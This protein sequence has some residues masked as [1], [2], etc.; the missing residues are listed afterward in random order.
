MYQI[1][2]QMKPK[3]W[4]GS[5]QVCWD[6]WNDKEEASRIYTVHED[7]TPSSNLEMHK[8]QASIFGS[9]YKIYRQAC[10]ANGH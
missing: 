2:K 5:G 10:T 8:I 6:L 7:D 4:T 3:L 9:A 1:L